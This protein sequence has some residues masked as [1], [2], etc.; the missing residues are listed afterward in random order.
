MVSFA[1]KFPV[2]VFSS[3]SNSTILTP[4]SI[5]EIAETTTPVAL[6]EVPSIVTPTSSEGRPA[7]G[8]ALIIF[9]TC[10]LHLIIEA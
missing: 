5:N 10:Q 7:L 2:W 6:E 4:D 3:S 1:I 9:L 8:T